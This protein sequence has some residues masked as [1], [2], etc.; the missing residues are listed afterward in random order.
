MVVSF[1]PAKSLRN[2]AERGLPF[3]RVDE[4]SW[5]DAVIIEDVRHDWGEL[6]LMV[7]AMLD[8]KLHVA[9]VT[10]RDHD[11][12]VI[13]FRRARKNEERLFEQTQAA[14]SEGRR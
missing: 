6:R 2:A 14:Q 1:D 10:P 3:G 11:L 9:V 12:R 8:G 13:S 7:I 4:L 5:A